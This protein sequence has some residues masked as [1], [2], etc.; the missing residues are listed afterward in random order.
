MR[1]LLVEND[2]TVVNAIMRL[3]QINPDFVS[4]LEPDDA[5]EYLRTHHEFFPQLDLDGAIEFVKGNDSVDLIMLDL[6]MNGKGR[7]GLEVYELARSLWGGTVPV[8]IITGC[9]DEF[10]VQAEQIAAVD[11]NFIVYKKPLT[12][13]KLKLIFSTAEEAIAH[14]QSNS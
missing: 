2:A 5:L 4:Q 13:D 3:Y 7:I 12:N 11:L 9:E 14:F 6:R 8:A 1:I 10:L